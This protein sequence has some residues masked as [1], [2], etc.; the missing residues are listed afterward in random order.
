MG[1]VAR[2]VNEYG[3]H[4]V[5]SYVP[6][7]RAL[8]TECKITDDEMKPLISDKADNLYIA[9]HFIIISDAISSILASI[10]GDLA[11]CLSLF[12]EFASRRSFLY[13]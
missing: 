12:F 13:D 8:F 6:T 5:E 10:V 9:I 4:K 1:S 2:W 3:K 11:Y 7:G